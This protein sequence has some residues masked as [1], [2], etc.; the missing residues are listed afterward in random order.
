MQ[1]PLQI[2]GKQNMI[3]TLVTNIAH[4]NIGSRINVMPGALILKMVVKK[5]IPVINVPR[6]ES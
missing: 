3:S 4:V 6:P 5:L 1:V 2:Q